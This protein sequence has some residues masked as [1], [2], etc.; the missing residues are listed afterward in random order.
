[1]NEATGSFFSLSANETTDSCAAADCAPPE[2]E[3]R[4]LWHTN[5]KPEGLRDAPSS[6]KT[7]VNIF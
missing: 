5:T 3:I 2:T 1:V 6:L 7:L 4:V